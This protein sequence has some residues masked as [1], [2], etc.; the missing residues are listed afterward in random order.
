MDSLG[1]ERA[2]AERLATPFSVCLIDIDHFKA[3]NDGFGHAAGDAVLKHFAALVPQE[4]RAIDVYGRFGG[5]EFLV[6]L[7][8]TAREGAVACAERVRA[9]AAAAAFPGLP[10]ENHVTVTVGVATYA[11]GEEVSALLARA[12]AALYQGKARG[13]NSVIAA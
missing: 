5:E 10:S 3:I 8:D 4:L 9:R 12:D 2:R 13:R 6:I 11:K 7:P 1:R